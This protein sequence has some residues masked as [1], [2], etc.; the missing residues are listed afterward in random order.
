R[1]VL[2][3]RQR[4]R[5]RAHG[6]VPRRKLQLIGAPGTGKTMSASELA[7]ELHFPLFTIQ[8]HGLMT[9]FMGETAAKLRLIFDSMSET[10]AVYLFGE[11]DAMGWDRAT[12]IVGGEIRRVLHSFLQFLEQAGSDSVIVA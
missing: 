6:L 7:G 5:L 8:L 10:R 11:F 9:K 1:V 3:H 12:E 4:D 2:E